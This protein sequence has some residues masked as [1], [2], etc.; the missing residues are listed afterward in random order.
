MCALGELNWTAARAMR[1]SQSLPARVVGNSSRRLADKAPAWN[2]VDGV[3][4]VTGDGLRR[5]R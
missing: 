5:N 3:N 4:K 2:V 1:A